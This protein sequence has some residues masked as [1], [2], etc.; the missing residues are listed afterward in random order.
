MHA[1]LAFRPH[2]RPH[3]HRP[4]RPPGARRWRLPLRKGG[5]GCLGCMVPLLTG[6]LA[7]LA[8]AAWT[9]HVLATHA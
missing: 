8:T 7:L 9:V 1:V 5:G 4:P 2:R 6:A 3:P